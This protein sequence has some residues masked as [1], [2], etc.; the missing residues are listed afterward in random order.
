LGNSSCLAYLWLAY[1]DVCAL[2]DD[3]LKRVHQRE[4]CDLSLFRLGLHLLARC[5]QDD[6]PIPAGFLVPAVLPRKPERQPVKQAA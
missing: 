4:R 5:L 3:W 1:L 2:H 6:I